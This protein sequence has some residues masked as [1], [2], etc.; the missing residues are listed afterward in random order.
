MLKPLIYA[1]L[2]ALFVAQTANV[3]HVAATTHLV[4]HSPSLQ[5]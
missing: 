3:P 5:H 1:M 2:A 4:L